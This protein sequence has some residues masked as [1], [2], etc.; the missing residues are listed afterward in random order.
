[1]LS[2]LALA[3]SCLLLSSVALAVPPADEAAADVLFNQATDAAKAGRLD[4]ACPKFA[5]AQ[6]LDPTAGTLL[7]LGKCEEERHNLATAYGAYIAAEAL[8]RQDNDKS[9]REAR[10]QAAVARI[11]PKLSMLVLTVAQGSRVEGIM[12]KRNGKAV[13]E[14]QWGSAIPVDP[15][16]ITIEVSAPGRLPWTT[17][18]QIESRPG[19]TT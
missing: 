12:V 15:G 10:A 17:T 3:P 14:G 11:E 8:A 5:E 9:G 16:A 4:E 7:N 13:G 2:V 18:V 19:P 1:M 6:R